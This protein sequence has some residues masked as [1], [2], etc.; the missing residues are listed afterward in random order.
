VAAIDFLR[1]NSH[2][3]ARRGVLDIASPRDAARI[4]A[5]RE[6]ILFGAGNRY[7]GS[8]VGCRFDVVRAT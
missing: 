1:G 2:A 6:A 4:R 7:P 8:R 5:D 3:A